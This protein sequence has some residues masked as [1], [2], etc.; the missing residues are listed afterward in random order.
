MYFS[1]NDSG[2]TI[3]LVAQDGVQQPPIHFPQG[4]HLLAFL[5]C[6]ENGLLP[7]GQL[8]PPLWPQRGK[9]TFFL[10]FNINTVKYNYRLNRI[11]SCFCCSQIHSIT[12]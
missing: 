4:G 11:K 8:D 2:G 1:G 7:H 9:G 5:T 6:L 12:T 10:V 3:V